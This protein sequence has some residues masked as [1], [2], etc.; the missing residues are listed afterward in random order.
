LQKVSQ[1]EQSVTSNKVGLMSV[2]IGE[3]EISQKRA[4]FIS[5]RMAFIST[6]GV[7]M[8]NNAFW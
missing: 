3:Q 8:Q 7:M 1:Q 4:M 2:I 5:G 6:S